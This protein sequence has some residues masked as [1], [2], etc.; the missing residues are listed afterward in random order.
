MR[1]TEEYQELKKNYSALLINIMERVA[2]H[3]RSSKSSYDESW[4]VYN[5]SEEVH[6]VHEFKIPNFLAVQSSLGWPRNPFRN[7]P[8]WRL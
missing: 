8:C 4:S 3:K 1:V 2:T 5:A 6:S 7:F